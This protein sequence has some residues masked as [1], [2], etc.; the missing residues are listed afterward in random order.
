MQ[1]DLMESSFI[2]L[3]E[4]DDN[5]NVAAFMGCLSVTDIKN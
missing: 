5:K 2:D 1:R 4:L 3:D